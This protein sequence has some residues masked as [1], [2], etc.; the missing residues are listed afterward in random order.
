MLTVLEVKQCP[1]LGVAFKYY[2]ASASAVAAVGSA[3]GDVLFP[4]EADAAPPTITSGL[5]LGTP[6]VTT[7][8]MT[9]TEMIEIADIIASVIEKREDVEVVVNGVL[10]VV[11]S[12]PV[13]QLARQ[14]QT[15]IPV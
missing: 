3:L 10:H 7:R 1:Q 13:L 5:R 14:C 8:G 15:L 11:V 9:E 12:V 4:A 2:M 6:C